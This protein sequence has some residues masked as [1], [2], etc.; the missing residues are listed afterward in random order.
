MFAELDPIWKALADQ[1]R[2]E[3]LDFLRLGPQTTTAI[4]DQFPSLTRF[5][6]MKH[7]Q[8]LRDAGLI[9]SRR[10]GRRR[11]NS[12]NAVPIRQIYERWVS[13]YAEHW[14]TSLIGLKEALERKPEDEDE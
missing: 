8:V 9:N 11:L 6:V 10:E 13:K 5:G 2:R 14:A 4:V 12:L 1:T 3:I 7:I